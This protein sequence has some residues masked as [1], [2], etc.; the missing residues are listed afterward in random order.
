[1]LRKTTTALSAALLLTTSMAQ[2]RTLDR[3]DTET[4]A[5]ATAAY[6]VEQNTWWDDFTRSGKKIVDHI[7]DVSKS[8]PQAAMWFLLTGGKMGFASR[9]ATDEEATKMFSAMR[10]I[11]THFG[12]AANKA[13][14]LE[15]W[16]DVAQNRAGQVHLDMIYQKIDDLEKQVS[17]LKADLGQSRIEASLLK[18][19]VGSL[20]ERI[21]ALEADKVADRARIASLEA[22][23]TALEQ[24][25]DQE[26]ADRIREA[27]ERLE[28]EAAL[29]K[30]NAEVQADFRAEMVKLMESTRAAARTEAKSEADAN[31]KLMMEMFGKLESR[32]DQ[33]FKV[34]QA[35]ITSQEGS[36]EDLRK[37][38]AISQ[39][40]A[41]AK[42]ATINHLVGV[43]TKKSGT[44]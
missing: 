27:K 9:Q 30:K 38:I 7:E 42:D 15:A 8:N 32:F 14:G 19:Q 5:A 24:K 12:N 23:N 18:A 10:N 34:Q 22:R 40:Q 43:L 13:Q 1:M 2:A 33:M 37:M 35:S 28:A 11:A 29:N 4:K 39:E 6:S 44:D 36:I 21:R 31:I 3:Y 25:I 41:R 17:D 20:E 26:R 16:K